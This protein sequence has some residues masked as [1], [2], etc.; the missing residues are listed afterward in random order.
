MGLV[1]LIRLLDLFLGDNRSDEPALQ[2]V[3]KA[4]EYCTRK[5]SASALKVRVYMGGSRGILFPM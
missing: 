2:D 3:L 4:K 5:L 1:D